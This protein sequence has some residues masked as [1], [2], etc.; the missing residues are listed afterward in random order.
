MLTKICSCCCIRHLLLH[1]SSIYCYI[2]P[3]VLLQNAYWL[4]WALYRRRHRLVISALWPEFCCTSVH[5]HSVLLGWRSPGRAEPQA[6]ISEIPADLLGFCSRRLFGVL[7]D[8]SRSCARIGLQNVAVV[9]SE[10]YHCFWLAGYFW[11]LFKQTSKKPTT[12]PL[13]KHWLLISAN[14]HL[15]YQFVQLPV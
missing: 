15:C 11:W 1:S 5:P 8:L 12:P 9:S 3:S 10:G 2:I 7:L 13:A 14:A 6:L 4:Q